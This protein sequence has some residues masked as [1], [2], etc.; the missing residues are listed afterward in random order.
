MSLR[1]GERRNDF[2]VRCGSN[3]VIQEWARKVSNRRIFCPRFCLRRRPADRTHN[4]RSRRQ[5]DRLRWLSRTAADGRASRPIARAT[6]YGASP[7]SPVFSR[8]GE[9]E[10]GSTDDH[11]ARP[12]RRVAPRPAECDHRRRLLGVRPRP[13]RWHRTS[14][15]RGGPVPVLRRSNSQRAR[16]HAPPT[17]AAAGVSGAPKNT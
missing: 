5:R 8:C 17:S 14:R 7:S 2:L 3:L 16:I 15:R 9:I 6:S 13:V 1:K 11:P 4:R 12:D 10:H